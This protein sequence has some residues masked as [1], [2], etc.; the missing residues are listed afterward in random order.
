[1]A[2]SISPVGSTV[3]THVAERRSKALQTH[4]EPFEELARL[5]IMR[6]AKLGLTQQQLADRMAS[7]KSVISRIESGHHRTSAAT[8]RRLAEALGG[9]AVI[10][11]QFDGEPAELLV[12]L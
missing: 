3:A 9:R 4:L 8:L 12:R 1:M 10:G 7:T 2:A 6:R 5:V 11:F